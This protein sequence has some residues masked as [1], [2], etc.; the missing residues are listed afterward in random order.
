MFNMIFK[1]YVIQRN[2]TYL[3]FAGVRKTTNQRK[4]EF[5]ELV[6][7]QTD[8]LQSNSSLTSEGGGGLSSWVGWVR[9]NFEYTSV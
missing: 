3:V 1:L 5:W 8:I 2:P 7:K 6:W 9:R 4:T